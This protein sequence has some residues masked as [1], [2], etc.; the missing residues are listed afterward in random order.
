MQI[1]NYTFEYKSFFLLARS[2][3]I[4]ITSFFLCWSIAVVASPIED[5]EK[6]IEAFNLG[7]VVAAMGFFQNAANEGY[8]PAQVRLA[9]IFEQSESNEEAVKWY[10]KAAEQN[11]AEG[12]YGLAEMYVSGKGVEQDFKQAILLMT[13]AAEQGLIRAIRNLA[14]AYERGGLD[15]KV[16]HNKTIYWIEKAAKSGDRWAI[17]RLVQAYSHGELG[18]PVDNE[19]AQSWNAKLPMSETEPAEQY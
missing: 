10:R 2:L 19:K 14:I 9:Y 16:D 1:L 8:A 18:L 17:G 3:T 6:G 11:N 5:T 4:L 12:Q 7:D 15:L 13:E